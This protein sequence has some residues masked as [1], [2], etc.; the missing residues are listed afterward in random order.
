MAQLRAI[1]QVTT[2]S[3][4]GFSVFSEKIAD[5]GGA[6]EDTLKPL[7]LAGSSEFIL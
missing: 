5:R 4:D 3:E 7:V 1:V 2:L 6:R